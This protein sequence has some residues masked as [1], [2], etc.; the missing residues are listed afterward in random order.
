MSSVQLRLLASLLAL[1]AGAGAVVVA[2]LLLHD[3]LG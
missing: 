1:A 3:V 2:L